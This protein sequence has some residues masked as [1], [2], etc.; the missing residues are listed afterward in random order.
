MLNILMIGWEIPPFNSGG[1]GV[2]SF[3]LALNLS[4][5]TNLIF[6]LPTYLP[7]TKQPFKIIF[8]DNKIKIINP[9]KILNLNIDF[10]L[11]NQVVSYGIRVYQKIISEN[12]K[13]DIIHAHDWLGGL[14]GLYLKEKL[15]KP[16]IIHVHSTE[17]ERTGLNPNLTIFNFE[18]ECFNKADKLIAVSN[19][20]KN[21]IKEFYNIN[22]NKIYVVPNGISY[23][24]YN[25]Y[26]VKFIQ[27]LKIENYKIVLFVGRLVLQKGPD[28]L[29][30]TIKY[31][32][33]YI[34][35]VKYIFAGSGEM[36]NDLIRIA[37]NEN[38]ID[39]IIFAGFL[40]NDEL[41]SIYNLSDVL[42]APSVFDPFGLVPLE[43]VR[44]KKPIIIS[45]T[46]GLGEYLN[47]C[48]RVDYWD[49][50]LMANYIVNILKYQPLKNELA[51]NAYKELDK[52]NWED[53]ANK[54]LE[55]YQKII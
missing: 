29:V 38:V 5:K 37:Y 16:L 46:T 25:Y 40:R 53:R 33:Q 8:A 44:F 50:K 14:A 39:N 42:V 27:N 23:E 7:L 19:L 13:I 22:E 32:K 4:K 11:L 1:L 49:I 54:I 3:Y 10:N 51:H 15:N 18:K 47:N 45:K 20:T 36:I 55:I 2:A 30:K 6:T 26:P 28:Y 12:L 34:P 21:I 41:W 52:F 24:E 48:L 35:K 9:Y 31:V 43:A 17:I